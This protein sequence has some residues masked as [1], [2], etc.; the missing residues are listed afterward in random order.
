MASDSVVRWQR[1][2]AL[3][4]KVFLPLASDDDCGHDASQS[5]LTLIPHLP[6]SPSQN[7]LNQSS[8]SQEERIH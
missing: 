4:T 7:S 5:D 8:V 2:C 6:K 3:H 1:Q